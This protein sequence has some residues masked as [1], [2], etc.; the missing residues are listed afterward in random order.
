MTAASIFFAVVAAACAGAVAYVFH[1]LQKSQA[2]LAASSQ[3]LAAARAR[4]ESSAALE[5]ERDAARLEAQ[6]LRAKLSAMEATVSE[7]SRAAAERESQL[8]ELKRQLEA[9]FAQMA[10]QALAQSQTQFLQLANETFEKH[11]TAASGGVQAVLAPVQ[12]HVLKLAATVEAMDKARA[13]ERGAL[14]QRLVEIGQHMAQTQAVTAKLVTALKAEPHTRGAWGEQTLRRVLE[15]A[16]LNQHVD[17][18]EQEQVS[19]GGG[20]RLRP[21]VIIKLPGG[22]CIV[23]DSKV[24][25][26]AYQAAVEAETDEL[27]QAQL[28][29]H[30]QQVR[31]HV[32]KLSSKE[33]WKA[34]P[35]TADFVVMFV[36]G[37]HFLSAAVEQ[38]PSLIEDAVASN[39]IPATPTTLIALAKAVAYGWRQE[40]AARNAR[41]VSALGQALYEHLFRLG[42]RLGTLGAAIEGTIKKYN[43]VVATAETGALVGA[44]KLK[45]LGVGEGKDVAALDP[46]E[47]GPRPLTKLIGA[48]QASLELPPSSKGRKPG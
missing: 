17:F 46:I 20:E 34:V 5:R 30:A 18:V 29:R 31:D 6:D 28:A 9:Q 41:E 26:T 16:G 25:L 2:G 27:R 11:Q 45:A 4:L 48:E 22:R 42:D 32:K 13:E 8:I 19:G 12:E 1:L 10:N 43:D 38:A 33:Y 44:R 36:A 24:A 15:I 21:D 23:V 35:E 37:E 40:D 14:S 39:V 7:R 3:E 47:S